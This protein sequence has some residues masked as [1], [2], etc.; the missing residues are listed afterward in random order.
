VKGVVV[1]GISPNETVTI[2]DDNW[3]GQ[4]VKEI[5][6][7]YS[8]GKLSSR[9][10]YHDEANNLE[11]LKSGLPWSFDGEGD[12][13]RIVSEAL[14]IKNGYLFDPVLAVHTSL[15]EPLPH[16]I[17]AVYEK[18]LP[19]QPLRYL[20]ADDPGA[21][22]TIMAGLFIKELIIRGDV[23]R[24]LICAPGNLVEQW[25]DEMHSRFHISFEIITN[26]KI[27]TSR[28]GNP[29]KEYDFVI[30]RLDHMSRS[31]EI[32]ARL[33]QTDWDLIVCDEAHKMSAT[34]FGGEIRET[35]RRKLGR[36]LSRLTRNFLLLTA[37]P[38]NGKEEDFQLFLSLLDQDRFEGK[39]RDGVH[40]ID[41]SDIMRRLV[42]EQL[43]RFDGTRLF[44]ERFAY[45]VKY[46]LSELEDRLYKEVT[47][48]V[49][50]E[51]NRADRL[52]EGRRN[53]VGFALTILQ[54]RLASSPEAIYQSLR[55]RKERLK[56]KMQ[57]AQDRKDGKLIE[58]DE[59]LDE[60]EIEDLEDA[61]E[62]EVEQYQ[63]KIVDQASAAQ[64]IQ[65]LRAEINALENLEKLAYEVRHSG[66]DRKWDELSKLLQDDKEMFDNN[67]GRRKLIIFTEYLDTLNYVSN[68]LKT[69]I[70]KPRSIVTIHGGIGR[71]ERK[72]AQDA[73]TQDKEVLILVATDAAG[74]GINLQ[75][76]H[77]MVNYDLPWNPNRI[78]QRFGRIHRIG[79]TE[80]CHLWN[81]VAPETREG[82]VFKRLFEKLEE[83][84]KA[85]GGQVFDVL[86]KVFQERPL[87]D[88][89]IEAVRY[90][91]RPDVRARLKEA[92]DGAM[93]REHLRELVEER[94]LARDSMDSAAVR[95][96][97]EEME[98]AEARRLQPHFIS[99]FFLEAFQL[100]GGSVNEREAKR[101]ELTY[102]PSSIRSRDHYI[103]GREKTRERYERITFEK[104]FINVQGKPLAEFVSPGH[105]LLD[106]TLDLTLER[107]KELLRR[108]AILV[109]P[110][111]SATQMRILFYLEST[112]QD[113]RTDSA[114]NN[115]VVSKEMQ[116][117][118]IDENCSPHKAGYAPY[119]DYRPI[120]DAEK[121]GI[122]DALDSPWLKNDLEQRA[123]T[124]A[125]NGLVP[126]HFEST[127]KM[128]E[129]L[130]EKTRAAVH[131]R[132]TKE[133]AYW[134]R[135]ANELKDQESQGKVN[136]KMNSGLAR[137]RADELEARLKNR[138]L[139]LDREKQLSRVPPVIMGGALV[140]PAGL[141]QGTEGEEVSMYSHDTKENEMIA[142]NRVMEVERSLG[143]LPHDV[144][145]DKC[146]YDIESQV[147]GTG[148]LKFIEVKGRVVGAPVVTLH[149]NEIL[150][151][152]NKP[153]D[154]IL[155]VVLIEN[156]AAK[157][158]RYV[159]KP[160]SR[161]PDF[162]VTSINYELKKLLDHSEDPL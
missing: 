71:Q 78:E 55:R 4:D 19:R 144:S 28:S 106:A 162:G 81:L 155:A 128:R 108:G 51:M 150:T 62:E 70:G 94:A 98:R 104:N 131:D 125:I 29:Y 35:K 56:K 143:R 156:R 151:G 36:L 68:R 8:S 126:K 130:V 66:T 124:Y 80:V 15:V 76:G 22:K 133:I 152:L 65:E 2:I 135:R 105:T 24:C 46:Q 58:E 158:V 38:H 92:V 86:G 139:E 84:R 147:P 122:K 118:E 141:L 26:E 17:T 50:N 54:R 1:R 44:P 25:Q 45:T 40:R 161:E 116:F 83:E 67:G 60:E 74:E 9:L 102:V 146:G 145:A 18:M 103:S 114:G 95:R 85:L 89:L 96:V 42:K 57:E 109:D 82:D 90:G 115:Y 20:L 100:L 154:F 69:L 132:L 30:S 7:K 138:M 13:F 88:L 3:R 73:F 117:V 6:Y 93:N 110:S 140:V 148:K 10:V 64:T 134:D 61:P 159:K 27:E 43:L 123:L 52:A 14:R 72:N 101:Y 23:K 34:F 31:H 21:G 47:D 99:A 137:K 127:K 111:D 41:T 149:K 153:E 157:T 11:V 119:L 37:T 77:L 53:V 63:Q 48:Y 16:Q 160:F 32:Q 142:M 12:K 75:R 5:S 120:T 97:R 136:A 112:I 33:E 113:A 87:R 107:Y 59:Q 121:T 49:R 91:D 39:F 79:Q 129:E